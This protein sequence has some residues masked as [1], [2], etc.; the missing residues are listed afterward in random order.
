MSFATIDPLLSGATTGIILLIVL[1]KVI[2]GFAVA[3]A[4]VIVM[5]WF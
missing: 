3:M 4:A 5:V 1:M 2:I